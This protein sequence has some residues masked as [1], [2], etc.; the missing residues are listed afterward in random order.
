MHKT[1]DSIYKIP[2]NFHSYSSIERNS[3][4]GELFENPIYFQNDQGEF[5]VATDGYGCVIT[6]LPFEAG[7]SK[8]AYLNIISEERLS[9]AGIIDGVLKTEPNIY[10]LDVPKL[11]LAIAKARVV[12]SICNNTEQLDC[13]YCETTTEVECSQC[14]GEGSHPCI[15]CSKPDLCKECDGLGVVECLDCNEGI[16]A[17]TEC[18]DN[19]R[20]TVELVYK[21]F[22]CCF[23]QR[24]MRKFFDCFCGKADCFFE[25]S[26]IILKDEIFCVALMPFY[27]P[28]NITIDLEPLLCQVASPPL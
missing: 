20:N 12:C 25:G 21:D 26:R 1:T 14:N 9:F 19:S 3:Y 23:K 7:I 28:S 2:A 8:E 24:L 5:A 16:M 10:Q 15:T 18:P 13:T 6:K 22:R 4:R 11:R 27:E 17:C